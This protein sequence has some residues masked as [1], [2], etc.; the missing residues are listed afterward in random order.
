MCFKARPAP[1]T[2]DAAS[3]FIIVPW[4]F[5][6]INWGAIAN[7]TA[8]V[9]L[10]NTTIDGVERLD[11]T[12]STSLTGGQAD[13]FTSIVGQSGNDVVYLI[14]GQVVGGFYRT[15]AGRGVDENLNA[16]GATFAPLRLF[17]EAE[18]PDSFYPNGVIARL[19]T[20][21]ASHE[22]STDVA[23]HRAPSCSF[24]MEAPWTLPVGVHSPIAASCF[25]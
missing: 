12:G 17:S 11:I 2:P 21:A 8:T 6:G 4:G 5:P 1:L 14:N 15:H 23:Q 16:P 20:L 24:A 3:T 25:P 18:L 10:S 7:P 22:L 19:A 13:A 9:N